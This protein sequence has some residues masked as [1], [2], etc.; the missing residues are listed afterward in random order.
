M[1]AADLIN[2]K[3]NDDIYSYDQYYYSCVI[4]RSRQL[5]FNAHEVVGPKSQVQP[6]A[7]TPD[8]VA[9]MNVF[10]EIIQSMPELSKLQIR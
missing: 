3:R 10:Y 8:I 1:T 7:M 9:N 2:V 5:K 4:D 6:L